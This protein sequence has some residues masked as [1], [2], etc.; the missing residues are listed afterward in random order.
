MQEDRNG[1]GVP[2]EM[3]YELR[4]GDDD[5]PAVK[6]RITRRYAV[7]Y[8]STHDSG[9]VNE[10]GQL[11]RKVYW[12]DSRGRTGMIPGGFPV[13]WGV[14]GNWVTYTCTLLRDDG[15]IA[16]GGYGGL[17]AS[18]YVDAAAVDFPVNKA[19]GVDGAPVALTAVKFIKVQTGVFRYG[20]LYGDVSTEIKYADFLGT[21]SLFPSP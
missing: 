17:I 21:Q 5:D 3:W 7:S 2:D 13:Y 18:G 6:D 9:S 19:M 1:N 10:Y 15:Q 20:G 16:T 12:A 14:A 11:I 4:G 8:F